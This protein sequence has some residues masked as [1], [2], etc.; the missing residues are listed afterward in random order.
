MRILKNQD[1]AD[2][3]AGSTWDVIKLLQEPSCGMIKQLKINYNFIEVE[4]G[5]F[6]DIENKDFVR[7]PALSDAS[8]RAFVLYKYRENVIPKPKPFIEGMHIILQLC[9]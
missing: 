8:P 4:N 6:F 5:W 2:A 7:D 9:C 3:L 1:V